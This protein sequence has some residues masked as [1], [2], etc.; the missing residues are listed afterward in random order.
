MLVVSVYGIANFFEG[1]LKL[2]SH[3]ENAVDMQHVVDVMYDRT[4][5]IVRH[6]PLAV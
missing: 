4:V 6:H 2:I 1:E 3:D 5:G